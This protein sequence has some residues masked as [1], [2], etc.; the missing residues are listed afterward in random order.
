MLVICSMTEQM[1]HIVLEHLRHIRSSVDDLKAEVRNFNLRVGAV[2][3]MVT[4]V[5]VSEVGQN[6]EIDR[7]KTRL[8]RIERRLDLAD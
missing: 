2:E 3:H 5:Q 8:D 6:A 7:L 4:G 1:T